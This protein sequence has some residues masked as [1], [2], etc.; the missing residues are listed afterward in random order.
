MIRFIGAALILVST[1]VWGFLNSMIPYKRYKNLIK[2][3]AALNAMKNEIRFSSDYID[4]VLIKVSLITDFDMIFKTAAN[5]DKALPISA[6]WKKAL[7][8]DASSLH[9]SKEDYEVLAMLG[10]ELGMT[11]REG[12]LKN[13]ENTISMLEVLQNSAKE[14]YEN[15]SKLKKGLGV[16][17]GLFAVII[18]F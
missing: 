13:I 3:I 6:R 5:I 7:Q 4:N 14:D 17:V 8:E 9:L 12:Q 10:A 2:I 16:S 18:L 1:S 15:M 11:D